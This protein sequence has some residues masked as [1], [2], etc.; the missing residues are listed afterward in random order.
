MKTFKKI[1]FLAVAAV[2]ISNCAFAQ[3]SS[4]PGFF[5]RAT[6]WCIKKATSPFVTAPLLASTAAIIYEKN[7]SLLELWEH[8]KSEIV[9][10]TAIAAMTAGLNLV[11]K[12]YGFKHKLLAA[13]TGATLTYNAAAVIIHNKRKSIM[14]RIKSEAKR[15]LLTASALGIGALSLCRKQ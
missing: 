14:E 11:L 10:H 6:N 4:E 9:R 3:E 12:N 1:L 5:S 8:G 7:K 13:F 15:D 2:S